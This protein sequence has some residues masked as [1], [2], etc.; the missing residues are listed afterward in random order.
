MQN[1]KSVVVSLRLLPKLFQSFHNFPGSDTHEMILYTEKTHEMTKLFFENLQRYSSERKTEGGVKTD[2]FYSHTA[3]IQ[4]RLQFLA[5]IFSNQLSA[6]CFRLNQSQVSILWECLA[7]DALASDDLFQWLLIQA[8]SKDQ[9]ALGIDSVRFIHRE[10]LPALSPET[11]TMTGLNLLSQLTT[12]VQMAD[13]YSEASGASEGSRSSGF[14][15]TQMWSI[16]LRANST[17]VSMKAIHLLNAAYLG[18]GEE[19]LI[20]CMEHLT[21]VTRVQAGSSDTCTADNLVTCHRAL[22]LLKSHLE[23]FRKKYAFQFRR[24]AIEGNPVSSHAELVEVRH[25]SLIRINV[26]P[27]GAISEK[28]TIDM[29]TSDLVADLRAE[30]CVWWE[31][32]MGG[33]GLEPSMLGSLLGSAGM[34]PHTAQT[35]LRLI[36]QGQEITPVSSIYPLKKQNLFIKFFFRIWMRGVWQ[37]L[38]SKISKQYFVQVSGLLLQE[39]IQIL[40]KII[41]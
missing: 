34:G 1:N 38:G 4:A 39:V 30:I 36:S 21:R 7:N 10:K 13:G 11:M 17:D 18:R 29:H 24:L 23:T 25:S 6:E 26:Q 2:S 3:H 12:L 9:H 27:G 20:T 37:N 19:F 31:G 22:L 15:M 8:H 40:Y 28:V 35:H 14:N 5:M 32:K 33:A 16:A 41:L